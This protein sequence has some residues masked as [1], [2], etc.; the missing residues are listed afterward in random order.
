MFW[1]NQ[2]LKKVVWLSCGGARRASVAHHAH[3]ICF[4]TSVTSMKT[5]MSYQIIMI[6]WMYFLLLFGK[7]TIDCICY[8][9]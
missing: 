5:L 4:I 3:G 9:Y 8:L 6:I 2:G 1:T 7:N